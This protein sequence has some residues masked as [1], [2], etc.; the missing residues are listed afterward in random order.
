MILSLE[1][2]KIRRTGYIPAFLAGGLLTSAVPAVHMA[3]RSQ[4]F[5]GLSG[6][7]F[8]ILMDA[9]W[10][11][12]AQLTI[13]LIV[14]GCSLMYNTEYADRGALKMDTLPIRQV[15]LFFGKFTVNLICII[16][17]LAMQTISVTLCGICWFPERAPAIAETLKGMGFELIL[18]L[19]TMMLMLAAASACRNMWISLGAGVILTFTGSMIPPKQF[20]LTQLPFAAPYQTLHTISESNIFPC[21]MI[22]LAEFLV[23]GAFEIIYLYIRR[24][25]S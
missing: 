11:M 12:M 21:L 16:L 10:G 9:N 7:P 25:L 8:H 6:T 19:P 2:K 4:S 22:C 24:K 18:L 1:F 14:C 20:A 13:L 3:A 15:C 5:T 23:F 17:V